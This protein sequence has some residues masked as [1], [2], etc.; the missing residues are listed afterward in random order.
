MNL[1][2]QAPVAP[3]PPPPQM[4]ETHIDPATGEN[5]AAPQ[6]GDGTGGEQA[7]AKGQAGQPARTP[8]RNAPC[9][10]GSGKKYKRCHGAL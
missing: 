3:P 9:P 7:Q 2:V 4:V 1:Q 6:A 5:L 8:P 10:C